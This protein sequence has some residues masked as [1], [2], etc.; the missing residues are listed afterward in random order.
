MTSPERRWEICSETPGRIRAHNSSVGRYALAARAVEGELLELDGITT[1]HVNPV[2]SRVLVKFDL[3]RLSRE[4]VLA[5]LDRATSRLFDQP[6]LD[7]LLPSDTMP[8][9]DA[10]HLYFSTLNLGVVA[11]TLTLGPLLA[12]RVGSTLVIASRIILSGMKAMFVERRMRVDVLDALTIAMLLASGHPFAAALMVWIVDIGDAL[13]ESSSSLSRRLLT[14]LFG[15][16]VRRVWLLVDDV[17]VEESL[18]RVRAG[19]L[20][21]VRGG[22]QVAADGMVVSGNAIIDQHVLT[23]ESAAVER[24]E[25]ERVFAMTVV[26]AGRIVVRVEQAGS[27]TKAAKIVEYINR[28]LEHKVRLQTMSEKFADDMVIPTMA[29]G[30]VGW[31]VG[32]AP[33]TAAI[34]NA[35]YGT[36]IRVA[37]PMALL[38]SL[39]RAA[40]HG[41]VIKDG[42]VLERLMDVTAVV[43]DKTGTLTEETP[44][45]GR[46]VPIGRG[47]TETRILGIVAAAEKRF[48]HPIARAIVR[49]A[50]RAGVTL[51]AVDETSFE[52]GFGV[53]VRVGGN[54]IRIGSRRFAEREG[55]AIPQKLR[56]HLERIDE[57][58]QSAVF[59]ADEE[60]IIGMIELHSS[61][62]PEAAG[63]VERL[64]TRRGI[65]EIHLVSG[66][67]EAA[68]QSLARRLDIRHYASGV[69]PQRK[70]D[71]VRELQA[72]GHKVVMVGDG[73]NDSVALSQADVSVSLRG[74]ADIAMDVADVIFMDGHIARFD[75]LWDIAED[76]RSNVERSVTMTLVSNS[77]VIIGALAGVFGIGA[78]LL[79]N[80]GVNLLA[81]LNGLLPY[82]SVL[83]ETGQDGLA[84]PPGDSPR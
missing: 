10:M 50:E 2:T 56:P 36:G 18:D 21:I 68:T 70:A 72:Q 62:R 75:H 71:Y 9:P 66:D 16:Q 63:I 22:E 65:D 39:A 52:I 83:R 54:W 25:G 14:N 12:L 51:P 46:I 34:I 11:A 26:L 1:Y 49:H 41:I 69:L 13:L 58:G 59:A 57:H 61:D 7:E 38:A 73:I 32:G 44:E 20:L 47:Y 76:L 17:E 28:S 60:K 84:A 42:A 67:H 43:F 19:D 5:A 55:L 74:A 27:E 23:G 35:D 30:G 3:R 78:S 81:T 24:S 64:R 79:L 82:Y 29:L 48:D 33:T 40:N 53:R 15:T 31:F 37:G 6:E 77:A 8:S 45:V 4:R 80:N